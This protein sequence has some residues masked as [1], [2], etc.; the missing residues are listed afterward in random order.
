MGSPR[1]PESS[2]WQFLRALAA[3]YPSTAIT[4]SFSD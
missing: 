2:F 4:F 1:E 3:S